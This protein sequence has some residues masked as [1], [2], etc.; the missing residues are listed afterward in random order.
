MSIRQKK[1]RNFSSGQCLETET[2]EDANLIYE[3]ALVSFEHY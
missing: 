3:V 1:D 2:W